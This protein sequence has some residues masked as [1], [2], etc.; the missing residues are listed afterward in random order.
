MRWGAHDEFSF[1]FICLPQFIGSVKYFAI[2]HQMKVSQTFAYS[3]LPTVICTITVQ[4]SLRSTSLSDDFAT[5]QA[6][7]LLK[8]PYGVFS[9][10]S[11]LLRLRFYLD[12]LHE[13]GGSERRASTA[14]PS[15]VQQLRISCVKRL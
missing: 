14:C 15:A 5:L 11:V 1:S 12:C 13:A 2:K 10:R 8:I 3:N 9:L 6:G 7:P 4:H